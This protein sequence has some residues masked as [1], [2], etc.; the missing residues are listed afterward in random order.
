[1]TEAQ[2]IAVNKIIDSFHVS[3][4]HLH[5]VVQ[6]FV[7][8]MEKGLD[9]QGATSKFYISYIRVRLKKNL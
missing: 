6:Q 7:I 3:D 2:T 5:K 8:E 1:M 9:H 4:E